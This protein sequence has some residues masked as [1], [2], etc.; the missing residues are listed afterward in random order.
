MRC[1]GAYPR[2][3]SLPAFRVKAFWRLVVGRLSAA[4]SQGGNVSMD[5]F[6]QTLRAA[7]G[8]SRGKE[9]SCHSI[10]GWSMLRSIGPTQR[11]PPSSSPFRSGFW[12]EIRPGET[13]HRRYSYRS[14]RETVGELKLENTQAV[15]AEQLDRSR[16][17]GSRMSLGAPVS[18]TSNFATLPAMKSLLPKP[19]RS[20]EIWSSS[21][22]DRSRCALSRS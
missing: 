2:A 15:T 22:P 16:V 7:T 3:N 17:V 20:R 18:C 21:E 13:T 11:A 8:W 19:I 9:Q 1:D 12:I 4:S 5:H 10:L 6:V 14:H